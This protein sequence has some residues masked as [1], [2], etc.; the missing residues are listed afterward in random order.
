MLRTTGRDLAHILFRLSR[1]IK[2]NTTIITDNIKHFATA[3]RF[4]TSNWFQQW[5]CAANVING[6]YMHILYYITVETFEQYLVPI[7]GARDR[8]TNTFRV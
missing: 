6:V 8:Q 5:C 1:I 3:V 2:S 7:S 4:A